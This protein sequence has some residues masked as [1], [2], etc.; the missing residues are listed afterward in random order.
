LAVKKK[1][2]EEDEYLTKTLTAQHGRADYFV[3]GAGKSVE[4]LPSN[5][6]NQA[7]RTGSD[8]KVDPM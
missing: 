7:S 8:F 6:G 3:T 4:R 2:G 1:R 5:F